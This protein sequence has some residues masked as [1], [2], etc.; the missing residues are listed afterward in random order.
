[1]SIPINHR[2]TKEDVQQGWKLFAKQFESEATDEEIYLADLL[3]DAGEIHRSTGAWPT[4]GEVLAVWKHE[5]QERERKRIASWQDA[6]R[7]TAYGFSCY[8]QQLAAG[9]TN[10]PFVTLM[11]VAQSL[12]QSSKQLTVGDV[13]AEIKRRT[14]KP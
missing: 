12:K 3:T 8:E 7:I 1:M 6:G 10:G 13:R 14:T 4:V 2:I 5:A 9:D 11:R